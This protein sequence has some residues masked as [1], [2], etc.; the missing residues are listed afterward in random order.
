MIVLLDRV[1]EPTLVAGRPERMRAIVWPLLESKFLQQDGVGVKMLLPI[2]LR[3][4]VHKEEAAFFQEARLDKQSVVDR[5]A[6]SGA[7]LYDL[8]TARLRACHRDRESTITLTD[9][10]AEDVGRDSL[11]EA[12]GQ[13]G[14]PRDAFKLLYSVIREHCQRVPEEAPEFRVPRHILE[15]IRHEQTRRVSELQRGLAPG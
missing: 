11:V 8:C 3:Y 13:M 10:F 4:L 6:W 2:E 14:Q 9:L 1:D 7:T 5:L 15:T 12:L